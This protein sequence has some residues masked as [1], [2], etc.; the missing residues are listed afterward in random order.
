MRVAPFQAVVVEVYQRV[1]GVAGELRGQV[2]V[3][4]LVAAIGE[5]FATLD[6]R[7]EEALADQLAHHG[8]QL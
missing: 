1:N 4:L 8:Q 2:A 7:E 3:Q 5:R 6:L